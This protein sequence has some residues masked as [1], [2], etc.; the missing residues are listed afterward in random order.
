MPVQYTGLFTVVLR[1]TYGWIT[2]VCHGPELLE[3]VLIYMTRTHSESPVSYRD[4]QMFFP[5]VI[6]KCIY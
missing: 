2:F 6:G 4:Q 3:T 5:A 1:T